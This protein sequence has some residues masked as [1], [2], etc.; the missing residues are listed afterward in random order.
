MKR[1]GNGRYTEIAAI[2]WLIDQA[3]NL[4]SLPTPPAPSCTAMQNAWCENIR[5]NTGWWE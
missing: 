1:S 5:M 4:T 3:V 2:R